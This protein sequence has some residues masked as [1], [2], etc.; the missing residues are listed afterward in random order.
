MPGSVEDAKYK[1]SYVI[2]F[3]SC[4]TTGVGRSTEAESRLQGGFMLLCFTESTFFF[5]QI[6]DPW[7]PWVEQVYRC[8]F[9]DSVCS[10]CIC[11]VLGMFA[12]VQTLLLLLHLLWWSVTREPFKKKFSLFELKDCCFTRLCS[13]RG[14]SKVTHLYTPGSFS[15]SFRYEVSWGRE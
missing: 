2:W 14:C 13:L 1:G 15:G 3:H 6:K 8:H 11:H 9:P 7:Q 5:L 12:V 4:D 10:L